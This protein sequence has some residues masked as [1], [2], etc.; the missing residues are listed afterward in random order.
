MGL[1]RALGG[2]APVLPGR[3]RVPGAFDA[4]GYLALYPDVAG[5]RG[6]AVRH[7]LRHGR[8][9][10]RLPRPLQAAALE[11]AVWAGD[12]TALAPLGALGAGG[13]GAEALW[14]RLALRRLA[15]V[16]GMGVPERGNSDDAAHLARVFGLPGPLLAL[17]ESA[18]RAGD[19][20]RA[21]TALTQA[22]SLIAPGICG[23]GA[24]LALLRAA[25]VLHQGHDWSRPLRPLYGLAGLVAPQI[26]RGD[27]PAFDRL[28]APVCAP[29]HQGPLVSIIMPARTAAQT[30][31]TALAGL[32]A[33]SWR[34]LEVLVVVNGS[35]DDTAAKVAR[36]QARDPRIRL[37]AGDAGGGAYG[38]RNLGVGLA[39]GAVIGMHDADD[40]SHPDRIARQ[41]HALLAAPRAMGCL[42]HW[43]RMTPDLCPALW[44]PDLAPAHANLSSLMLR[45]AVIDRVGLWDARV[46][47]GA[48]TEYIDRMRHVYGAGA[49]VQ[50]LPGLPL[51]FGRVVPG[52]LTMGAQT[53]LLGPGARA[54]GAYLAAARDWHV[55]SGGMSLPEGAPFAVPPL[56]RVAAITGTAVTGTA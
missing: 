31:D 46:R 17:A 26:T 20:L 44:R 54:R 27:G 19:L 10:G 53:G 15:L 2:L 50:V 51:A 35:G 21:K 5:V 36:W 11:A 22:Q 52:G 13:F 47:A 55:A 9:E 29:V 45:R 8:D 34:A 12:E 41:M 38:A 39:Q 28:S 14:A 37:V 43:M 25:L 56:L 6:G 4:A 33:Q 18:L 40:W 7:F 48:D 49:L 32:S 30:I 23:A 1:A 16:Q 3:W 42:S 24:G